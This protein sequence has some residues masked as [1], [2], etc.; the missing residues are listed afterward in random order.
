MMSLAKHHVQLHYFPVSSVQSH[1]ILLR[2]ASTGNAI[3]VEAHESR[4][5]STSSRVRALLSQHRIKGSLV[6]ARQFVGVDNTPH[7]LR[8]QLSWG[9]SAEASQCI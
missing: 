1:Q 7:A 2:D 6:A 3:E 9:A 8:M 5:D 4:G